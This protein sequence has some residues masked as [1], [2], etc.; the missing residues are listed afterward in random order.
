VACADAAADPVVA[1][2]VALEVLDVDCVAPR[3]AVGR[4]MVGVIVGAA[5]CHGRLK[6]CLTPKS[7]TELIPTFSA[8]AEE[9]ASRG[10]LGVTTKSGASRTEVAP[11]ALNAA[12][13][14]AAAIKIHR[15]RLTRKL[16]RVHFL[17]LQFRASCHT[18]VRCNLCGLET[19]G[20]NRG[21]PR[22]TD[23]RGFECDDRANGAARNSIGHFDPPNTFVDFFCGISPMR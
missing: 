17:S 15:D 7:E 8:I 21:T 11:V 9:T 1:G 13:S 12:A 10:A 20:Y 6:E 14:K 16:I 23:S 3:I 4:T 22:Q 19:G 5:V 18:V 2:L